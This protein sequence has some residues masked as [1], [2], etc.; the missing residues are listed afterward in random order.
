MSPSFWAMSAADVFLT[1]MIQTRSPVPGWSICF[2]IAI[3]RFTFDDRSVT[4]SA[5][6]GA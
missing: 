2:R 5:P 4:I 6:W 1:E 3:M